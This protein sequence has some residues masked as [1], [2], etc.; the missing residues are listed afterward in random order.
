MV[1]WHLRAVYGV[2]YGGG[3]VDFSGDVGGDV[4][5]ACDTSVLL[6]GGPAACGYCALGDEY[7]AGWV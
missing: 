6:R 7:R 1:V 5:L 2:E 4:D 3:G